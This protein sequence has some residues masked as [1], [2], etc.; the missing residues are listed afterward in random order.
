MHAAS[1]SI[2][3]FNPVSLWRIRKTGVRDKNLDAPEI[4]L[5][6]IAGF[7][8]EATARLGSAVLPRFRRLGL[9]DVNAPKAG[10]SSREAYETAQEISP[11]EA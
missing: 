11:K 6:E 2:R 7:R 9:S 8:G 10:E 4:S 5:T 1:L 3:I